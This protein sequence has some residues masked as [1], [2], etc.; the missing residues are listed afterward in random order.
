MRFQ[1]GSG[2]KSSRTHLAHFCKEPLF[3]EQWTS[4]NETN[5][6]KKTQTRLTLRLLCSGL[7]GN[8]WRAHKIIVEIHT[9]QNSPHGFAVLM[10]SKISLTFKTASLIFPLET[11]FIDFQWLSLIR[12]EIPVYREL[13][14]VDKALWYELLEKFIRSEKQGSILIGAPQDPIRRNTEQL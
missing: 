12:I 2:C 11:V 6:W 9:Q 1:S 10:I 7:H 13:R 5:E 8:P 3:A 14:L 4:P